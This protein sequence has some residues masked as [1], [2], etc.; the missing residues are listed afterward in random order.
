M[1]SHHW[2]VITQWTRTGITMGQI[3]STPE[4]FLDFEM[5]GK[6]SKEE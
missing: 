6:K 3:Q 2:L 4:W 1:T 5:V